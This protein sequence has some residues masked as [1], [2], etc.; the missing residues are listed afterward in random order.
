M[1]TKW[2]KQGDSLTLDNKAVVECGPLKPVRG[3]ANMDLQHRMHHNLSTV[4]I[5]VNWIAGH[6]TI[7]SSHIAQQKADIRRNHESGR[8]GQDG[9]RSP[10]TGHSTNGRVGITRRR[11]AGP[12]VGAKV[13]LAKEVM[14]TVHRGTLGVMATTQGEAVFALVA[15]AMEKCVVGWIWGTMEQRKSPM[16]TMWGYTSR[17]GTRETDKVLSMEARVY[18]CSRGRSGALTRIGGWVRQDQ[19]TFTT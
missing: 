12:N 3:C 15:M 2:A 17:V 8:F 4:P 6:Q 5:L 11:M 18:G 1:V 13:D 7:R 9:S 16:P 10:T 19:R 14:A